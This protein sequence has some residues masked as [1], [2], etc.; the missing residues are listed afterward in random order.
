M[1][2]QKRAKATRT[3]RTPRAV[4]A[5][6]GEAATPTN[7]RGKDGKSVVLGPEALVAH[8]GVAG[9][10]QQELEVLLEV[11]QQATF[12]SWTYKLLAGEAQRRVDFSLKQMQGEAEE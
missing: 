9:M 1:T 10:G 11:L 7:A 8:Q 2:A 4:K 12:S 6:D 3:K 5:G